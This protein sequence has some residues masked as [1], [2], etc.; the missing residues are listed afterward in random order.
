[1]VPEVPSGVDKRR[2]WR[3]VVI[4]LAVVIVGAIAFHLISESVELKN[5]GV[6]RR[7]LSDF[8]PAS[9]KDM[10]HLVLANYY[11]YRTNSVWW[12]FAY[13]GCLFG[14]AFAS[15]LA[16][17]VLKLD[18]LKNRPA[19]KND[20]AAALAA[21][22]ALL[23]T[24]STSGDFQRKWQAN[25]VAADAMENL[26]YDLLRSGEVLDRDAVLDRIQEIN[27]ARSEGVVGKGKRDVEADRKKG[28]GAKPKEA[29]QKVEAPKGGK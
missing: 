3:A 25:R 21:T 12:S 10:G 17:V 11:E 19:L 26:S 14:S 22:A 24:L 7:K 20:T 1:M 2:V 5:R 13:F 16:G 18:V 15:A 6:A 4:L 8:L 23:I 9:S 28:D 29:P 27:Q